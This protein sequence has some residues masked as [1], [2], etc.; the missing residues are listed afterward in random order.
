MLTTFVAHLDGSGATTFLIVV[1]AFL[2]LCKKA[3]IRP[4]ALLAS[5]CGMYGVMNLLPWGGPTIRAASVIGVPVNELYTRLIPGLACLAVVLSLIHIWMMNAM[6]MVVMYQDALS[7]KPDM[8]FC[9]CLLY[10]SRCV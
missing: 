1:P 2:P 9:T 8:P 4:Q 7:P 5:M 10:T 3:E 6:P